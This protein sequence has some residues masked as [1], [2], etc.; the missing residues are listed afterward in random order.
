VALE[1]ATNLN[2]A[3]GPTRFAGIRE[4]RRVGPREYMDLPRYT[5]DYQ[6]SPFGLRAVTL[7]G[8]D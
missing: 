4:Q 1:L 3:L 5:R 6:L 2:N 7:L 8:A